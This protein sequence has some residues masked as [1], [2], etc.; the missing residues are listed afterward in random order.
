MLDNRVVIDVR[1]PG[2]YATGHLAG[3]INI[4]V[5]AGSFAANI[6]QLDKEAPYLV[7]CRSGRRSAIAAAQ[8]A[9]AGFTDI[10]D[11]GGLGALANAGAPLAL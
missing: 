5:E 9:D 8:M 3:A 1:T 11:A 10:I 2:E 6:K 4:D 7:Y